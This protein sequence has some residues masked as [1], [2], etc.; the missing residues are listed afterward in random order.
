M[1]I[2]FQLKKLETDHSEE[3]NTAKQEIVKLKT[4][5]ISNNKSMETFKNIIRSYRQKFSDV[6]SEIYKV[7][8]NF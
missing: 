3:I 5:F 1:I 2:E 4:K 8:F 6:A 7:S